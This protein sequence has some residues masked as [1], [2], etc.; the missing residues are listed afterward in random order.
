MSENTTT[1]QR[2]EGLPDQYWD[3]DA[4]SVRMTELM[5]D[6]GEA[7]RLKAD[8]DA[9]IAA[10]PA[11]PEDYKMEGALPEGFMVPHGFEPK[12]DPKDSRIPALREF[13]HKHKLS[14]EAVS[15]LIGLDLQAQVAQHLEADAAI[16]AEM[17]KL[18]ENAKARIKAVESALATH[19][20]EAEFEAMRP[21]VNT[22]A[23]VSA[24]E[25]IL[26]KLPK[27]PK[28]GG[29]PP[30]PERPADKFYAKRG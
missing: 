27:L 16:A 3:S 29:L 18:G 19:L 8:H 6:Y 12:V 26:A 4:G 28:N 23:A 5:A 15:K 22:A 30:P 20:D 17:Q 9:R 2:P 7:A 21:Y 11:K 24:L 25:K 14:Q 1:A 13:A 10:L